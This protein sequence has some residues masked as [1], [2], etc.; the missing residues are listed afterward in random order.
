MTREQFN[1][2]AKDYLATIKHTK[3][4]TKKAFQFWCSYI[5]EKEKKPGLKQTVFTHDSGIAADYPLFNYR[6]PHSALTAGK[7]IYGQI[8]KLCK[9]EP[10]LEFVGDWRGPLLQEEAP[11]LFDMAEEKDDRPQFGL[12]L[13]KMYS[14]M[15][16]ISK[17]L[18]MV[19]EKLGRLV[20]LE[21]MA[22]EH[23]LSDK[24]K[25]A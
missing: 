15:E 3:C 23:V 11:G 9:D 24:E 21:D 17:K 2:L 14:T 5:R 20:V 13:A 7:Y 1:K 22:M 16:T 18:D 10:F 19:N 4:D 25:R 6:N 12:V 8:A